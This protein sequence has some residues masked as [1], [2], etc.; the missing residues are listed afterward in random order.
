[1]KKSFEPGYTEGLAVLVEFHH[2]HEG[3]VKTENII[4]ATAGEIILC[5]ML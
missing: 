1:M 2:A 5:A 3:F 4:L